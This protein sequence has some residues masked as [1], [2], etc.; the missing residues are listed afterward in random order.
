M[1]SLTNC[2][3][4][5]IGRTH[6]SNQTMNRIQ[7]I[8][9]GREEVKLWYLQIT[10][11][12]VQLFCSVRIFVTY[13]LQHAVLAFTISLSLFKLLCVE[14]VMPSIT[15][16]LCCSFSSCL[17]SFP[18]SGSFPV[19]RLFTSGGQSIGASASALVLPISIQG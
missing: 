8:Q 15:S 3:Q 7:S 6:H 13:G 4:H 16:V 10:Y 17:Q 12:T 5:N 18:K 2:I 11:V 1:P 14:L 19:S 9:I